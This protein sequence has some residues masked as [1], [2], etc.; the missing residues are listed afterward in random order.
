MSVDGTG[1]AAARSRRIRLGLAAALVLAVAMTTGAWL[2]HDRRLHEWR[3]GGD[4][5]SV[6]ASIALARPGQLVATLAR[7]GVSTDGVPEESAYVVRVRWDGARTDHGS[8]QFVL[9]D[10]RVS[11]PAPITGLDAWTADGS[12]FGP[13]WASA[14]DSL[15]QHY[16]WLAG[17]APRETDGGWTDDSSAFG[18]R[19]SM[20]GAGVMTFTP[21]PS[22]RAAAD[23]SRDLTLAIVAVAPDGEVRW[24]KRV[25]LTSEVSEAS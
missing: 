21:P 22:E 11:P 6:A 8:Y 10:N 25:P 14:Y 5:V 1:D 19:T 9:L 2:A 3:H 15:A 12:G 13:N 20:R 18:Y 4:R 17:T 16:A 7:H 23:L 24:A